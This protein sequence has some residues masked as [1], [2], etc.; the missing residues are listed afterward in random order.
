V[1]V[2]AEP[3]QQLAWEARQRPRAAIA[4]I[5]A[6][7]LTLA[8]YLWAGLGLRDTP[9]AGFLESLTDAFKPGPIG[10]Q[11]SLKTAIF[12]YYD[13]H[14]LTIVG[15]ATVRGPSR[16]SEIASIVPTAPATVAT[17]ASAAPTSGR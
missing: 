8:G 5:I 13:E 4:A 12:E 2:I 7:F 10:T 1:A 14:A 17:A 6:G 11:P 9:R 3:E 16:K 15:S